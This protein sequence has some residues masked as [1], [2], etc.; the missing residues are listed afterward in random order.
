MLKHFKLI[1][2]VCVVTASC[3]GAVAQAEVYKDV[4]LNG[5]PAKL[6]VTTGEVVLVSAKTINSKKPEVETNLIRVKS[7]KIDSTKLVTINKSDTLDKHYKKE[8]LTSINTISIDSTDAKKNS[9]QVITTSDKA[10]KAAILVYDTSGSIT[11]IEEE[12]NSDF[13]LVKKGET[14]YSLSKHYNASLGTL[15]SANNLETTLIKVGQSLRVRNFDVL[16]SGN[17]WNVSKGDT[18][19][20]IARKTNTT[21]AALKVLNGLTSNLIKVGQKLQLK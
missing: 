12:N 20:S 9:E 8:I 13:H 5:K 19:Y 3:F 21:V 15:K 4:L 11:T 18:L 10:K 14:L 2:T 16:Y 7:S 6:N 17:V 1:I